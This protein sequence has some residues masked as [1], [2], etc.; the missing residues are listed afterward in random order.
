MIKC[1]SID[2]YIAIIL[3]FLFIKNNVK[4]IVFTKLL[5]ATVINIDNNDK[6]FLEHQIGIMK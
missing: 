6:I 4:S 3:N 5:R 1:Y 2:I